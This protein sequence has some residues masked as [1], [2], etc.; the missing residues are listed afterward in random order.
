M[1]SGEESEMEGCPEKDK[2]QDE[3]IILTSEKAVKDQLKFI[4]CEESV[5]TTF[6][7]CVP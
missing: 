3:P 2:E 4:V 5:A 6:S 7:A 1:T